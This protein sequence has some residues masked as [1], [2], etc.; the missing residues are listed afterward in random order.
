MNEHGKICFYKFGYPLLS[1]KIRELKKRKIEVGINNINKN[2]KNKN[3]IK[4]FK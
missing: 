2:K 1:D 3:I 4:I